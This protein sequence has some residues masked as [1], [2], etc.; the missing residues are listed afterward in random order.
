[1]TFKLVCS[2]YLLVIFIEA[3]KWKKRSNII[4]YLQS[5]LSTLDLIKNVHDKIGVEY[6]FLKSNSIA[7]KEIHNAIR[8]KSFSESN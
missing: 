2:G 6:R 4:A 3:F 5:P 7:S 8:T 1:M